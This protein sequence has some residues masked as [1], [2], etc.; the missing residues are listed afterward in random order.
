MDAKST[1]WRI[2][3]V[4]NWRSPHYMQA[5][6]LFSFVLVLRFVPSFFFFLLIFS[7]F[8]SAVVIEHI[9][10]KLFDKAAR[11]TLFTLS[12]LGILV[13]DTHTIVC[14]APGQTLMWARILAREREGDVVLCHTPF[15][16][17]HSHTHTP[18]IHLS[19]AY[20]RECHGNEGKKLR[21][22]MR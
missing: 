22:K 5:S 21:Q 10:R 3:T 2:I 17:T 9:A 14:Y 20:A 12:S 19:F 8:N 13:C 16:H 11:A 6:S 7:R 1:L 18:P 4:R 15:A